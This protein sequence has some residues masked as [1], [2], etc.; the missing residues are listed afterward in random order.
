MAVLSMP[1]MATATAM[2]ANQKTGVCLVST[3]PAMRSVA[4]P[5]SWPGPM[6][7]GLTP[8][9]GS[10]SISSTSL[11]IG[12]RLLLRGLKLRV[13]VPHRR[14]IG[15]ARARVQLGQK[16][17]VPLIGLE[18]G[19]A[20]AR[21]VDVAEGDGA[22]RTNLLAGSEDVAILDLAVFFF[23]GDARGIDA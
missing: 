1:K 10:T 19:D 3:M 8:F 4:V 18:L 13:R 22:G 21:I 16:L 2:M 12:L 15:G 9:G 7:G 14:N 11:G 23:G 20:T 6:T 5:R 17:V